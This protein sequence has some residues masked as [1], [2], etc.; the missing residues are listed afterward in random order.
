MRVFTHSVFLI[1]I[2]RWMPDWADSGLAIFI[3]LGRT[4]PRAPIPFLEQGRTIKTVLLERSYLGLTIA[5]P[6]KQYFYVGFCTFRLS[7]LDKKMDARLDRFWACDF[8][9][10]GEDH[11]PS[12]HVISGTRGDH[13]NSI[14]EGVIPRIDD[15]RTIQTVFLCGF[16][17]IPSF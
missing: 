9:R 13:Q 8:Y 2:K 3:V 17:H 10:A 5:G 12:T 6:S 4:I 7:D 16:L 11:P 1:S 15:R 14:T